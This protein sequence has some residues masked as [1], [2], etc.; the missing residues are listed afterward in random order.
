MAAGR[1]AR[2]DPHVE[3]AFAPGP[4]EGVVA[5]ESLAERVLL[6]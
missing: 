1:F 2:A 3:V 4:L 6:R 5:P